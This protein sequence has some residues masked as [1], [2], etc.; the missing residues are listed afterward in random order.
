MPSPPS[1][2]TLGVGGALGLPLSA[3]I[4]ENYSWHT[5]FW[6]SSAVAAV[7]L[8]LTAVVVPNV[9]DAHP[10]HIDVVGIIGLAVGLSS[11]LIGVSKG[12][13]WGWSDGKTLGAII[14]GIVV[15]LA[16]G[17]YE[18]RHHDPLVDL[19]TTS[20]RPVLFTNLAALLIGFGMMAQAIVV[21]QLLQMPTATGYGLGQTILEAGLWMAPGGLMMLVFAPVSA[22]MMTTIGA[23]ITLS[24][25]ALV[26][27]TG[28]I[29][30][31]FLMDAPWQLMLASIVA[32]A[33]VGIGYAAMPTLIMDN[34]PVEEA[35]SSVGLNGLD[36]LG[37]H[38]DRRRRDGGHPHQQDHGARAR[39]HHPRPRRLQALLHRRRLRS[40]RRRADRPA[41]PAPATAG[42]GQGDRRDRGRR[43]GIGLRE[44]LTTA[45]AGP[46][47]H[48]G[49]RWQAMRRRSTP[50]EFRTHDHG[51]LATAPTPTLTRTP[52]G[53]RGL[54]TWPPLSRETY[55]ACMSWTGDVFEKA[56]LLRRLRD[57]LPPSIVVADS[58]D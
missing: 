7:V 43:R 49:D 16:W 33:G 37:R 50:D 57:E 2:A 40:H 34:V 30:A 36:A 9:H 6:V 18:L 56:R 5:L 10:A 51:S 4:A 46:G 44:R 8:V 12:S 23:R 31:V 58:L 35:G 19:R 39:R 48:H 26:T 11:F 20:R 54:W 47:S 25:G 53:H 29:V 45:A 41:G 28:Y 3:W 38:H 32:S 27:G 13:T 15:M 22:K 42:N 55:D 17:W 1:R 52:S 24:V 14:G 21:P